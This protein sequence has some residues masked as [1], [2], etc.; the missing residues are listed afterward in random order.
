MDTTVRNIDEEAYRAL[1]AW[2]ALQGKSIGEALSAL[3]WAH[4]G[5][6]Q[7]WPRKRSILD[8]AALD[9]GK[10]TTRLSEEIDESVYGV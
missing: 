1:K 9:F 10:G 2:A 6:P 7:P 3:I 4:V 5:R 8:L